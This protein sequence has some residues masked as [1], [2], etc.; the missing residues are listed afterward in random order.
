[1]DKEETIK[2]GKS[3]SINE[4]KSVLINKILELQGS[5]LDSK[6]Q[7]STLINFVQSLLGIETIAVYAN[8]AN[9][10]INLINSKSGAKQY[11]LLGQLLET[12]AEQIDTRQDRYFNSL[13]PLAELNLKQVSDEDLNTRI[14]PI[15]SH[16]TREIY[17]IVLVNSS[18]IITSPEERKILLFVLNY[19]SK[20]IEEYDLENQLD[21]KDYRLKLLS[22][23][24]S[25][26]RGILKPEK[27]IDIVL[28]EVHSFLKLENIYY[29][30]WVAQERRLEIS[31]EYI[32]DK[33]HSLKGFTHKVSSKNPIMKLLYKNQFMTYKNKNLKKIARV[34]MGS[35]EPSVFCYIPVLIRT[36]LL[37]VLVL[38]N[39]SP[40]DEINPEDIRIVQE[41]AGQ[42][43]VILN[44]ANLYEDRKSVV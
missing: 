12:I 34:F 41:I 7:I 9:E 19:I 23:L 15:L 24:S 29:T 10:K 38:V 39:T 14:Y 43:A 25:S 11:P 35:K 20:I 13:I 8:F 26:L 17:G 6:E 18:K 30:K 5:S 44:Q 16:N 28:K 21:K 36:D 4:I 3:K 2:S 31:Q 32:K 40:Y 27:A 22:R 37:G 42:L 1:M 33:K